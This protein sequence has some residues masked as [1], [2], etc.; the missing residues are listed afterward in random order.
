MSEKF[1]WVPENFLFCDKI[2]N[3]KN[4]AVVV[5]NRP[6]N[7]DKHFVECLWN[8]GKIYSGFHDKAKVNRVCLH[9]AASITLTVDGGTNRWM[10]WLKDNDME[11]KLKHPDLITG[12]MDSCR[13]ETIAYFNE[14]TLSPTL[15]QD[16]TDFTKSIRLIEPQ[17]QELGLE[18]IVALCETSGRMDQIFA[19]V[20]SKFSFSINDPRIV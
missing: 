4:F 18:S 7:L 12:D 20:N 17:I 13:K 3:A 19:N 10:N 14:S 15:D 1:S 11:D 8:Q 5:L 16:E 6:I 9:R 2:K